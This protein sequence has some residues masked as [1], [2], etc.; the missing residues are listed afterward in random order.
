[1]KEEKSHILYVDDEPD[2]LTVFKS[3]FRRDYKIHLAISAQEA[4]EI[5]RQNPQIEI[6]ITD[7]RMPEIT[8]VEFLK[9]IIPDYPNAIRMI[10][11]GFSDV[12]AIIDSINQGQVYRYI[13]K[14]WEK[15]TLKATIDKA[16][17]TYH[18]RAENRN[19]IARLQTA[20]Q[21]MERKIREQSQQVLK[22]QEIIEQKD[23]D[24]T[25]S[26]QY[27]REIQEAM[28][29][30]PEAIR[31]L[32]PHSFVFFRPLQ[33]VSGD[34]YWLVEKTSLEG[35]PKIVVAVADCTGHGIP[36]GFM[37]MLGNDLLHEVVVS[38]SILS[39]DEILYE[40]HRQLTTLLLKND[41]HQL[42]GMNI[43]ICCLD[44]KN[45][46]LEFAGA[47]SSLVYIQ[48]NTLHQIKGDRHPIAKAWQPDAPER[49]FNKH[50][51]SLRENACYYL[52]SDGFQNQLGG[53]NHS[54]LG[55]EA[56][57]SL[58]HHIHLLSPEEQHQAISEKLNIWMNTQNQLMIC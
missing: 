34:F 16:I 38:R 24:L 3:T 23:H 31:C 42:D 50:Q 12:E 1:M 44:L 19:L 8:G 37:T 40:L 58:L 57:H 20:N 28:L 43:G 41:K 30:P 10:L 33:V 26:L 11:T 47:R 54:R 39:P 27:A 45:R 14:P 15:D 32:L 35:I 13:T 25:D 29:L 2:N 6:I 53:P 22:Q 18:H 51:L 9:I 56:F 4:I 49:R 7:Q 17:Q 52:F 5:L 55:S 21:A 48:H 36:G 46:S